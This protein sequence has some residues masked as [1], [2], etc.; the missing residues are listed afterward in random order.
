VKLIKHLND[1]EKHW[2]K[3]SFSSLNSEENT[4]YIIQNAEAQDIQNNNFDDVYKLQVCD[5]KRSVTYFG[6]RNMDYLRNLGYYSTKIFVIYT[7]HLLV[8]R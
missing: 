2:Q 5:I 1:P 6:I 8:L 4:L 7:D 3:K